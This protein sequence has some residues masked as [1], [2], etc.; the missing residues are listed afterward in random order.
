MLD[1]HSC[2]KKN[3]SCALPV[4]ALALG[5]ESEKRLSQSLP[6]PTISPACEKLCRLKSAEE[7]R[8]D[9]GGTAAAR[10][11]YR[12]ECRKTIGEF[13]ARWSGE[14]CARALAEMGR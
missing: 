2:C 6:T 8:D 4:I 14:G 9:V 3:L 5:C 12:V 11:V 10:L 7:Y 1:F 13:D